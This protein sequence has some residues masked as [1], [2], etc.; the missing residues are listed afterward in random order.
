MAFSSATHPKW[1]LSFPTC[2]HP[3]PY[4]A[5][6]LPLGMVEFKC[7][8]KPV[9][10]IW[11]HFQTYLFYVCFSKLLIF[12]AENF[13]TEIRIKLSVSNASC[14]YWGKA[15]SKLNAPPFHTHYRCKGRNIIRLFFFTPNFSIQLWGKRHYQMLW[16][17]CCP[18]GMRDV[19]L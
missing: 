18:P 8:P 7:S 17:H 12:Y 6:V 14:C 1:T 11:L 2:F 15:W 9:N 10:G 16:P 13:S 5:E 19:A 4:T 3:P